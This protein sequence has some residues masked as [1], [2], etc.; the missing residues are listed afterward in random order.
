LLELFSWVDSVNADVTPIHLVAR[1]RVLQQSTDLSRWCHVFAWL[2]KHRMSVVQ[3]V[4]V[5]MPQHTVTWFAML[6]SDPEAIVKAMLPNPMRYLSALFRGYFYLCEQVGSNVTMEGQL[7]IGV[8]T[9]SMNCIYDAMEVKLPTT[10]T[11]LVPLAQVITTDQRECL[12]SLVPSARR[13]KLLH[14]A[15]VVE[16]YV[17]AWTGRLEEIVCD[18]LIASIDLVCREGR[19][20]SAILSARLTA[21][22]QPRKRPRFES[23]DAVQ[24]GLTITHDGVIILD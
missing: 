7:M 16:T 2:L 1:F 17:Q 11:G 6:L 22:E 10:T 12:S 20:K 8:A 4:L 15:R 14:F 18:D 3:Q 5:S 24:E 9:K 21:S 23:I 19:R 13:E